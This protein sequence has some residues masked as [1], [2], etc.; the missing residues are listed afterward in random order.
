MIW[1]TLS[2]IVTGMVLSKKLPEKK[3]EFEDKLVD[4]AST[5]LEYSKDDIRTVLRNNSN[6]TEFA[7]VMVKIY[8]K[9]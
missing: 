3:E 9:K 1:Q 2:M 6:V 8:G 4:S 7:E 5:L